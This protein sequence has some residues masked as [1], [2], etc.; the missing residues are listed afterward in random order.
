MPEK[1]LK[2]IATVNGKPPRE[3]ASSQKEVQEA[4]ME[5]EWLLNPKQ[6]LATR[7][8]MERERLL[9]T[10]VMLENFFPLKDKRIVDLGCGAGELTHLLTEKGA[11]VDAVDCAENAL[12]RLKENAP[13]AKAIHDALPITKLPDDTY[14]LSLL[15]DVIAY[16]NPKEWRLTM[17]ELS[18]LIT[19][20]GVTF[21]STPI[22]IHSN[23]AL[24][25]FVDILETEFKPLSWRF[26][27]H[28]L[29]IKL[30]NLF[31]APARLFSAWKDQDIRSRQIAKRQG[32]SKSWFKLASSRYLGLF[33]WPLK[34]LF[35]PLVFLFEQVPLVMFALE[36]F[37]H[38]FWQERGISHIMVLAERRPLIDLPEEVKIAL[39]DRKPFR[40]ERIW[41]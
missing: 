37:S 22:D 2:I 25:R 29:T 32:I 28:T 36:K 7:N 35:S 18:R 39:P 15:S 14:D 30:L 24:S 6:F 17:A 16:L 33:W 4:S 9:R 12:K 26:S 21:I 34:I 23:D 11:I 13:K 41:E 40:K 38:F 3:R 8:A 27:Y 10:I 19:P 5:R 1:P 31:K 20:T